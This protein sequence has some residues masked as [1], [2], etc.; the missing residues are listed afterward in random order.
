MRW[1]LTPEQSD[2]RDVLADW[3]GDVCSPEQLREWLDAGDHASFEKRLLADGWFGVGAPE[4]LGG[5]GGG[6][7]E[8][9][10]AAEQFG[11]HG[12]PSGAWLASMVALPA[13]VEAPDT[14]RA[15]LTEGAT[16]VLASPAD[17]LP[18]SRQ[19]VVE[20]GGRLSGTVPTVL[21]AARARRFVV[22]DQRGA[23]WLVDSDVSGVEVR[24]RAL[25]DQSRS[26]ADVVLDDTT[27]TPLAGASRATAAR[28]EASLRAAVLVAADALGAMGRMLDATVEYTGQRRQFGV[29]IGSFQAVKHAAAEMLV[30]VE[31]GRSIVYLAAASVGAG[32]PDAHLHAAAAK[33]QVCA[34][35]GAAADSAL[36][37][38]GA[39][40]YTWE[41]ELQIHYKRALLD[42]QLFG[43]PAA[44]NDRLADALDLVGVG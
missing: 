23:S 27:G 7:V 33:A 22:Q 21:A 26:V 31:S 20:D 28:R 37:L 5:E 29:P 16:T 2:F 14:A 6:L 35:A 42:A 9:A 34:G 19:A 39:I 41:H 17:Q 15:M 32:H 8:L 18:D 44:W 38:H 13:L 40:G 12:A 30:K 11:R 24:R 3:L 1:E 25:T 10:L 43:P 36:L 4:E